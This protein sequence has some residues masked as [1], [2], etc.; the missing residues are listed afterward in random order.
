MFAWEAYLGQAMLYLTSSFDFNCLVNFLLFN[1]WMS[2][3]VT[4]VCAT[5]TYSGT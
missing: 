4:F 2:G 5:P 1:Y 3:F